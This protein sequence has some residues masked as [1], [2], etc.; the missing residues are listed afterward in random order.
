M[1]VE[2]SKNRSLQKKHSEV[3]K[4][5]AWSFKKNK[6]MP[7]KKNRV[8]M[9]AWVFFWRHPGDVELTWDSRGF[10][11][12]P[13]WKFSY[14]IINNLLTFNAHQILH[15]SREND[16]IIAGL[17][18]HEVA[19]LVIYF[20]LLGQRRALRVSAAEIW[21]TIYRRGLVFE[22]K[23]NFSIFIWLVFGLANL[24]RLQLFSFIFYLY[25]GGHWTLRAFPVSDVTV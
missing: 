9:I 19:G 4:K 14:I 25:W 16:K 22:G 21:L 3:F 12:E 23:Y 10:F 11:S 20:L 2:A 13:T 18:L 15:I 24:F 6:V 5:T 1:K 8:F 17:F 7:K